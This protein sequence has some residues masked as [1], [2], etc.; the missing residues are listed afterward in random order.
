MECSRHTAYKL[1]IGQ[2]VQY[3]SVLVF[4][5][6][7]NGVHRKQ[8]RRG[9]NQPDEKDHLSMVG[10]CTIFTLFSSLFVLPEFSFTEKS[11]CS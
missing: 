5:H 4:K 6:G 10:S 3:V 11:Y 7:D 9:I 8:P 1:L 2:H